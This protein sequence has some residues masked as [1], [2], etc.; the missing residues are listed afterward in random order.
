M[1]D[2]LTKA[3]GALPLLPGQTR[4]R[5]EVH[6]CPHY[7][8]VLSFRAREALSTCW[9]YEVQLT[10]TTPDIACET[11]LLKPAAFTFQTPVFS[12]GAAVPVRTVYGVVQDFR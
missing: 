7:L 8:D 6:D 5:V 3:A 1:S 12:G 2:S 10:C 9:H 11:F 4:Y